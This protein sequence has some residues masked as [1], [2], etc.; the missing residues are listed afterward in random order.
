MHRKLT[1]TVS[2]EVCQALHGNVQGHF[3]TWP[4]AVATRA[5]AASGR[6]A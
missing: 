2:D 6:P 5:T 4:P 1:I 3:I